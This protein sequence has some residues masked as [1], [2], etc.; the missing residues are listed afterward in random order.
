[1][2]SGVPQNTYKQYKEDTLVFTTWLSQVARS[3]GWKPRS[4]P[5]TSATPTNDLFPVEQRPRLKSRGR[6]LA[7]EATKAAPAK[8][9]VEPPEAAIKHDITT[10]DLLEQVD[11]VAQVKTKQSICPKGIYMVLKRAI[12]LRKRCA[13]WYLETDV[14]QKFSASNESHLHFIYVLERAA[15][16]L[17]ETSSDDTI[18]GAP[19]V[20]KVLPTEVDALK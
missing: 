17:G 6:K 13:A 16:L 20:T 15:R 3:C 1:M 14:H 2:A 9:E 18:D 5:Q 19:K 10:K 12:A 11:I 8:P 4:K 7:R